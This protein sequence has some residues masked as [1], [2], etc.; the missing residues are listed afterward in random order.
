[1]DQNDPDDLYVSDRF[2]A[3]RYGVSRPTIWAWVKLD[4]DFP[5]PQ[6]L[7][8]GCTRFSLKAAKLWEQSRRAA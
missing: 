6:K 3:A 5:R 1:M 4:P 7:S 8:P 2:L